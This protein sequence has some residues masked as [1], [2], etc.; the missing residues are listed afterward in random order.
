M[1]WWLGFGWEIVIFVGQNRKQ[2]RVLLHLLCYPSHTLNV[3]FKS[4]ALEFWSPCQ[5]SSLSQTKSLRSL[6]DDV[7]IPTEASRKC[8]G[9]GHIPGPEK[10]QGG[11]ARYPSLWGLG[12]YI[13]SPGSSFTVKLVLANMAWT[14]FNNLIQK[15]KK[16]WNESLLL[17]TQHIH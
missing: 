16:G 11:P 1:A 17:S 9:Q 13:L 10:D 2:R 15:K 4:K 5:H 3:K 6:D 8:Q 12:I 14:C 7:P